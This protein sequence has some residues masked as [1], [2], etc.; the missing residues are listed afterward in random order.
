MI[1]KQ[2]ILQRALKT[3][4]QSGYGAVNLHELA[5]SLEMSRGNMTYHFKDKEVLLKELADELWNELNEARADKTIPSFEN[6]HHDVQ[7]YYRLQKK[8]AF[9]FQDKL[10]LSHPII[11]PR[12]KELTAKTIRDI[13]MAIAFSIQIGNM[14]Q[15]PAPGVYYN[16]AL[17]SWILMFFWASQQTVRGDKVQ[18]DGE[19]VI[20]S[21]LLPHLTP[22]GMAS[23]K[24]YF[25]EEY[26][27]SLG[28]AFDHSLESYVNF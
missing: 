27:A 16:L 9:I 17:T 19:K 7:L 25:G 24:K 12:M 11:A 15:E 2:K 21:L 14:N 4:N 5:K 8:Y 18:K 26:L 20:W 28:K 1:T 3:F 22:K 13:E 10:V 6:L 23:F